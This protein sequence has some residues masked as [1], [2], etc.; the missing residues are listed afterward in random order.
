MTLILAVQVAALVTDS[1][2]AVQRTQLM[3]AQIRPLM[4]RAS[5]QVGLPYFVI[6][7]YILVLLA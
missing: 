2:P 7:S 3:T 6:E 5:A 4:G 1:G